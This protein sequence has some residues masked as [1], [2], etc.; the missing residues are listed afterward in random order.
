MTSTEGDLLGEGAVSQQEKQDD[1]SAGHSSDTG[2]LTVEAQVLE[3]LFEVGTR[4]DK[5]MTSQATLARDFRE[6][7]RDFCHQ[8]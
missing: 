7:R 4:M 3:K 8:A 5:I 6:L 1:G 2:G